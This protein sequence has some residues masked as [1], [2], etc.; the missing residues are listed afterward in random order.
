MEEGQ[1]YQLA[2]RP[3]TGDYAVMNAQSP[4]EQSIAA[5]PQVGPIEVDGARFV[6][7]HRLENDMTFLL[8]DEPPAAD[9][10]VTS[11]TEGGWTIRRFEPDGTCDSFAIGVVDREGF[12][13][14]L[15]V[16]GKTGRLQVQGPVRV[17]PNAPT[18]APIA[19]GLR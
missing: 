13:V 8:F 7:A 16:A 18:A 10:L 11:L 5:Q 9:A 2:Y 14:I 4:D 3:K 12:A 17:D 1:T 15:Q 6:G 19:G